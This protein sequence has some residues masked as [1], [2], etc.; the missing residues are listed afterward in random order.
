MIEADRADYSRAKLDHDL[1]VAITTDNVYSRGKPMLCSES[2]ALPPVPVFHDK[3]SALDGEKTYTKSFLS[4]ILNF[5]LYSRLGLHHYLFFR[6]LSRTVPD[7]CGTSANF[8]EYEC[9]G[10]QPHDH[11]SH[12]VD[13]DPFVFHNVITKI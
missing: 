5:L 1:I 9:L 12:I 2:R 11:Q 7:T 3:T 6:V 10:Y 8:F 4:L 13:S